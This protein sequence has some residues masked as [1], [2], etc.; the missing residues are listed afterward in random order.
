MAMAAGVT[1]RSVI[2]Y[3]YK[4]EHTQYCK[5]EQH[6]LGQNSAPAEIIKNSHQFNCPSLEKSL[7][8][9]KPTDWASTPKCTYL[10]GLKTS[11]AA[12]ILAH[13]EFEMSEQTEIASPCPKSHKY[14]TL[15]VIPHVKQGGARL[16]SNHL[17]FNA[18]ELY[19]FILS[20]PLILQ[21]TGFPCITI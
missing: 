5:D 11:H 14:W 9:T 16:S 4:A 13:T 2:F 18:V 15:R 10:K 17:R 3:L 6:T 1:T 12:Q 21:Y 20:E 7:D 8:K 19:T